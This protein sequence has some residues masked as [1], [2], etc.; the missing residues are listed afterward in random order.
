MTPTEDAAPADPRFSFACAVKVERR[1]RR[2][3]RKRV[4][5]ATGGSG[6]DVGR[7]EGLAGWPGGGEGA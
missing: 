6:S 5:L 7:S 3:K 2:G 1:T 4:R